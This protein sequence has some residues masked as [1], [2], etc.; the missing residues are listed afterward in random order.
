MTRRSHGPTSVCAQRLSASQRWAD[1]RR[2]RNP[3]TL[4]SRAQRLSASQRWADLRRDRD[5]RRLSAQRLS[6]S[7]RWAAR[8]PRAAASRIDQC[9]TPF[10]ITEVGGADAAEM[11]ARHAVLNAF[12]HHRGGRTTGLLWRR[13]LT[14]CAQRLSAS[15]RWAPAMLL[16]QRCAELCS[17]PFGITEVGTPRS[18]PIPIPQVA[19]VGFSRACRAAVRMS[20]CFR[21]GGQRPSRRKHPAFPRVTDSHGSSELSMSPILKLNQ[22]LTQ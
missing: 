22:Q 4:V 9:S 2:A 19:S 11:S 12:R 15:Q 20:S 1:R 7:Q 8:H 14:S 13:V 6:A 18:Q 5:D 10:G 3:L 16:Q 21:S 17:T